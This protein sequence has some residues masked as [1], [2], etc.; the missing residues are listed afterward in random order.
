VLREKIFGALG[1]DALDNMLSSR[2]LAIIPCIRTPGDADMVRSTVA[3]EIAKL[4]AAEGLNAEIADAVQDMAGTADEG[5]TWR[6][7][8]AA[9]AAADASRS[10]Q[11]DM[12]EYETGDNGA[13]VSRRELDA[14]DALMD[15]IRF[16]KPGR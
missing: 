2:H 14:F 15:K 11:E 16:T 5:V 12:A 13:R 6:L 10:T 3:E 7:R 4:S 9:A 1:P 8:E